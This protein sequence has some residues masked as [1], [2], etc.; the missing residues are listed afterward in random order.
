MDD[1]YES[2]HDDEGDGDAD[3]EGHRTADVLVQR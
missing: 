2:H 3:P 1:R